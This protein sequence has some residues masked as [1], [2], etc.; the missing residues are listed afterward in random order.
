MNTV[1]EAVRPT[2]FDLVGRRSCGASARQE[3]RP[4]RSELTFRPNQNTSR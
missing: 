4:T 2:G 3:A 1:H